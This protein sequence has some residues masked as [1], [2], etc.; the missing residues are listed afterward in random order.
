[1]SNYSVIN[2]ATETV[3]TDV[4]LH[5]E[6]ETD[7]LIAKAVNAFESWRKVA[8]GERAALL[9]NFAVE[10]SKEREALAELEIRNSGHTRGN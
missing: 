9:R 10:V 1:M 7:A 2:P 3:V 6:A 5:S 8:P 4:H